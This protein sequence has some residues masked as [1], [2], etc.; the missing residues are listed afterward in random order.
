MFRGGGYL[1]PVSL[2]KKIGGRQQERSFLKDDEM[3]WVHVTC[4]S[5][6]RDASL[7]HARRRQARRKCKSCLSIIGCILFLQSAST[8]LFPFFHVAWPQEVAGL[9]AC[10]YVCL[11]V[12]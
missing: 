10:L 3:T 1:H 8:L 11:L 12:F 2:W 5:L 7:K 4:L 9:P 6:Y